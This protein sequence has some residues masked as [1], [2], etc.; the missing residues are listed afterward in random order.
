MAEASQARRSMGISLCLTASL[1]AGSSF[2]TGGTSLLD[3]DVKNGTRDIFSLICNTHDVRRSW[4][5]SHTILSILLREN[6]VPKI[7][8][9]INGISVNDTEY[10][11]SQLFTHSRISR[12]YKIGFDNSSRNRSNDGQRRQPDDAHVKFSSPSN[13]PRWQFFLLLRRFFGKIHTCLIAT[14]GYGIPALHSMKAILHP[15]SSHFSATSSLVLPYNQYRWCIYWMVLFA[16]VQP[17]LFPICTLF[18]RGTWY[19]LPLLIWLQYSPRGALIL[20]DLCVSRVMNKWGLE[21]YIERQVARHRESVMN[22]LRTWGYN[23]LFQILISLRLAAASSELNTY[24]VAFSSGPE[25][26][27]NSDP[28]IIVVESEEYIVEKVDSHCVKLNPTSPDC[29]HNQAEIDNGAIEDFYVLISEGIPVS[30]RYDEHPYH[31][32]SDGGESEDS[33]NHFKLCIF[34]CEEYTN[35]DKEDCLQ[36]NVETIEDCTIAIESEMKMAFTLSS[37]EPT[38]DDHVVR[39]PFES[40][41]SFEPKGGDGV[42]FLMDSIPQTS[43]ED[44]M[45]QIN[46]NEVIGKTIDL[47][48]AS[49]VSMHMVLPN[50]SDRD[51]LLCSISKMLKS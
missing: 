39:I 26:N 23:T 31:D 34:S 6:G 40:I 11:S 50:P 37:I 36:S 20:H 38:S 17:I 1:L 43:H 13:F 15:V 4:C 24:G 21:N 49:L 33:D 22:F 19:Q 14:I 45:E 48:T 28:A 27:C 25:T 5:S 8:N 35:S 29:I 46:L 41:V 7:E 2:L 47:C 10:E 44:M 18:F 30:W 32:T 42:I 12:W 16:F 9:K 3:Y 51:N